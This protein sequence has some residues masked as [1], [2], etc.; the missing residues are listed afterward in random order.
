MKL[1]PGKIQRKLHYIQ[2]CKANE[3]KDKFSNG[4]QYVSYRITTIN[5][6]ANFLKT[7]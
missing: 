1:K 2:C 3:N 7:L 5:L 6:T 4:K